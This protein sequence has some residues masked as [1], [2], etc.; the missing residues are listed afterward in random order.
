MIIR[1][2]PGASATWEKA[3]A[4][5]LQPVKLPL[6]TIEPVPWLPPDDLSRFDGLLFTSANT[7][8][9]A[10][11]ALGYLKSLAVYAVGPATA[12]AAS[13][14]GFEVA[15]TGAAGID[16][17]LGSIDPKLR[18]LHLAGEDRIEPGTTRQAITVLPVY[19][20]RRLEDV[21]PRPIGGS[22]IL[23]HSPR[24]GARLAEIAP[25]RH[26]VAIAAMSR[27]A[28]EAC[29]AGWQDVAVAAEPTD[30]ALL[31]LAAGLCEKGDE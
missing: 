25:D 16:E 11:E 27:A 4:Q 17:L 9:E 22:V 18:L 20:S 5:G 7:V 19:R 14:A 21:D 15:A 28:A 24:A 26:D 23:V 13:A 6:F 1:P 10:G 12:K 29:G 8:R 30:R 2:E 3:S 31:A